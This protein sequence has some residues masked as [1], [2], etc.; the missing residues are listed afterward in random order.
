MGT[1]AA[2]EAA[3]MAPAY[4]YHRFETWRS[5][6]FVVSKSDIICRVWVRDN[7]SPSGVVLCA[8]LN[9]SDKALELLKLHGRVKV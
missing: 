9:D 8:T 4:A 5:G 6:G 3:I 7:K 2:F 1:V